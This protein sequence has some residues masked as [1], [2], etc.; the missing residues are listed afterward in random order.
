MSAQK[1]GSVVFVFITLLL[2]TLGIGLVVPVL[3]E[4]V[5]GLVGGDLAA[6]SRYLG[7]FVAGSAVRQFLF[8]SFALLDIYP[9]K[10][11]NTARPEQPAHGSLL[12]NDDRARARGGS[13]AAS[14]EPTGA[15][16]RWRGSHSLRQSVRP[17]QSN[18][19]GAR[20]RR[21]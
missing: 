17:P 10:V 15:T 9:S 12:G 1:K 4:L 16:T 11:V 6:A 2:D 19:G 7:A 14:T 21:L 18:T 13:E 8:A 20:R 5:R 3:P